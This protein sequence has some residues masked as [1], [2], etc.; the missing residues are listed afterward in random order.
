V[1]VSICVHGTSSRAAELIAKEGFKP[2]TRGCFGRGIYLAENS[3]VAVLF[4]QSKLQTNEYNHPYHF[5]N[6]NLDASMTA[7]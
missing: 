1:N 3:S 2:S 5:R 4:A 6:T 7:L